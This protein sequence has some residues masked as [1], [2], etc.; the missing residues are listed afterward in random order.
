MNLLSNVMR[1]APRKPVPPAKRYFTSTLLLILI[2]VGPLCAQDFS[3]HNWYFGNSNQGIR[4]SR[5]DNSATLT[6]NKAN[7][8]TGGSAVATDPVNGNLLFYTDGATVFDVSHTAMPNG[9]GLA[10]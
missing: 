2:V 5:S 4:F 6:S 9:T 3:N 7:L 10:G 8:G 1:I